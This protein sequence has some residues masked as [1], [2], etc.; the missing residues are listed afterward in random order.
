MFFPETFRIK[1]I[2]SEGRIRSFMR[3][4]LKLSQSWIHI[5]QYLN[6]G[7]KSGVF[8]PIPDY[9]FQEMDL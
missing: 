5:F 8:N 3:V 4:N 2:S 1:F 9:S 6:L 7:P